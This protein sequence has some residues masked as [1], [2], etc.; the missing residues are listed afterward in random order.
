MNAKAN[1]VVA[2][3]NGYWSDKTHL[4]AIVELKRQ[5]FDVNLVGICDTVNPALM[6]NRPNLETLLKSDS[7]TWINARDKSQQL[8]EKELD[9]LHREV[10]IDAFIVATNPIYHYAYTAWAI[11]NGINVSCDK[12]LVVTRNASF[13]L[14]SARNIWKQYSELREAILKAKEHDGEFIAITPLRR[15]AIPLFVDTANQL[16]EVYNK[17]GEGIRYFSLTVNGGLHK[18]PLELMNGGAHG[19]LDGVGSLSHSSYHYI[20][21]IAWYLSCAGGNI[22]K[23]EVELPYMFRV[24][25][26]VS[27]HGY[28]KLMELVE[29][30]NSL[31]IDV[32][33]PVAVLNSEQ[34]FTFNIKLKDENGLLNGLV[35]YTCN[36]TTFTPRTQAYNKDVNEYAESKVGGRMSQVYIDIH[37]GALQNIQ[38]IKNDV[39]FFGNTVTVN[40]RV[41]PA[42]GSD[43]IHQEFDDAYVREATTPIDMIGNFIKYSSGM[44]FDQEMLDAT[45]KYE[46]QEF[47]NKLFSMFY[48]RI[49]ADAESKR[50]NGVTPELLDIKEM[51]RANK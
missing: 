32:A 39:V 48:E 8:V 47:T 38:L 30:N 3:G 7:P 37:Q 11:R 10:G 34:D 29:G 19:Y 2:G 22:S 42:L 51:M 31:D 43:D 5:G 33:L 1:V 13:D 28:R 50:K 24:Q 41:H 17:T 36:H 27:M 9:R 20:D 45:T 35:T 4:A 15:R 6:A 25:D 26:Y 23:I 44:S 40:R 16:E 49:A 12:P 46:D 21:L 18:Y 14:E